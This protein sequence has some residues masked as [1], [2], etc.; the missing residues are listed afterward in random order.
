M[1]RTEQMPEHED[2][3]GRDERPQRPCVP[4]HLMPNPQDREAKEKF[5]D[6]W[7]RPVF[8]RFR[9]DHFEIAGFSSNGNI[10][11]AVGAQAFGKSREEW[12]NS[13]AFARGN[14]TTRMNQK[15]Q[16]RIWINLLTAC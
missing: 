14:Q 2:K 4:S 8:Q 13:L 3:S 5:F 16:Q 1:L 11:V 6:E 7:H 9:G 10:D 12:K 15:A